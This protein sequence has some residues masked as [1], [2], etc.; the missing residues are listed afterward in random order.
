MNAL[1]VTPPSF[2]ALIPHFATARVDLRLAAL[3]LIVGAAGSFLGARITSLYVPGKVAK[4]DVRPAYRRD[5]R[6]QVIFNYSPNKGGVMLRKVVIHL[7]HADES[8]LTTG[9]HVS[10]RIRQV[11]EE[12]NVALEVYVFGPAERALVDRARAEFRDTL[13]EAWQR[14]VCL[15]MSAGLSR[16]RWVAR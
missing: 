2:S 16:R 6:L 7:F 15:C 5:D 13:A 9:A 11:K 10:E 12:Q 3:L 14:L 8:S 1:A 4:T